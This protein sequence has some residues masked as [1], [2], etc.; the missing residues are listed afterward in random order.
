M[1]LTPADHRHRADQLRNAAALVYSPRA[2]NAI[3]RA[4]QDEQ[5]ST[6]IPDLVTPWGT[7]YRADLAIQA[8]A[9]GFA[10]D[11][12]GRIDWSKTRR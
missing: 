6:D 10:V 5:A 12:N 8:H 7:R 2:F 1:T 3:M 4:I 9:S 11:P